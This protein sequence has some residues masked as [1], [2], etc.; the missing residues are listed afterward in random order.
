MNS[1][2]LFSH[3]DLI[4]K[5]INFLI[6]L[7]YENEK[8]DDNLLNFFPSLSLISSI[9]SSISIL[10]EIKRKNDII[11]HLDEQKH[12]FVYNIDFIVDFSDTT[13]IFTAGMTHIIFYLLESYLFLYF[14][15]IILFNEDILIKTLRSY[16]LISNYNNFNYIKEL[17][18]I[19][20]SCFYQL[21]DRI[22]QEK[23]IL[24]YSN[25]FS[26][27]SDY[28][29]SNNNLSSQ[30]FY[31]LKRIIYSLVSSK[32]FIFSETIQ[33]LFTLIGIISEE[34]IGIFPS[35]VADS[36]ISRLFLSISKKC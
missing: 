22:F 30:Y 20:L 17:N 27:I 12:I 10:K 15:E 25:F 31:L 23:N 7:D 26:L 19:F 18:E 3:T 24:N 28:F 6:N 2:F 16:L 34:N 36:I 35:E 21:Y 9:S 32:D 33:Y 29:S 1:T 13:T 8:I 14:N 5:I 11:K 4:T